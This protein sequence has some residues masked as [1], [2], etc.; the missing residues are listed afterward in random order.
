MNKSLHDTSALWIDQMTHFFTI[1]TLSL[2]F[3]TPS[4]SFLSFP[5][6]LE[7]TCSPFASPCNL[8]QL[9]SSFCNFLLHILMNQLICFA[10]YRAILLSWA[11]LFN[12]DASLNLSEQ[13]PMYLP[14]YNLKTSVTLSIEHLT[15]AL[16]S[17]NFSLLTWNQPS[18]D[19]TPE[20][21]VNSNCD[22]IHTTILSY[23]RFHVSIKVVSQHITASCCAQLLHWSSFGPFVTCYCKLRLPTFCQNLISML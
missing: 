12:P 7:Q 22:L 18:M 13:L 3:F 20:N 1:S 8:L 6:V 11:F 9:L 14:R 16:T 17:T 19:H 23:W 5:L 21:S 2:I 4:S 15:V 10:V